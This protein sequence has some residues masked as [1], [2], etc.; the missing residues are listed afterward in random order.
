[1]LVTFT[2]PAVTKSQNQIDILHWT[3]RHEERNYWHKLVQAYCG[4]PEKDLVP[5]IQ[6]TKASVSML[7][8]SKRLIDPLNVYSGLK[9][10]LDALVIQGWIRGDTYADVI[11]TADQRKCEKGE[12]PHMVVTITY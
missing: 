12:E 7:R 5:T 9:W 8:V 3:K 4:K 6:A 11:V 1:L 10:L 2:L